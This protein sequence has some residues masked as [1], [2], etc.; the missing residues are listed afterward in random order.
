MNDAVAARAAALHAE[1]IV[2]DGHACLPSIGADELLPQIERYRQAGVSLLG[3]NIGDSDVDLAEQIR[4][5]A[6]IR[7]FVAAHPD[8]YRMAVRAADIDAAHKAGQLAILL[9][10]EGCFAMGDQLSLIE[11]YFDIGVRWMA[12]V[13]NR[14]NLVGGGVHDDADE[15]LTAFGRQVVAEMD[16]VG[17]VK[18]CSHTGYRTVLEVMAATDR[19][20]IF[21]HS[22][23]R[24]LRD[25]PRNIPDELIR[26]CASTG[27]VVGLSGV[28]IFLGDNDISVDAQV[29]HVDYVVQMVGPQH[30]GLG[31]DFVFDQAQMDEALERNGHLWPANFGYEPGIRF[32]PPE[33]LP[34][35]TEGLLRR[36]YAEADVRAVMGGNLMRV[37]REVWRT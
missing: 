10:I 11:F 25:H 15:G 2:W 34:A 32:V 36:G 5:A 12:M 29:R 22:N 7:A 4:M 13:Y 31:L 20:T 23:P 26:A 8:R 33:Q 3:L 6:R 18:C 28:G 37:A 16:R 1:A 30:V 14:R 17:M 9:N 19:P 35:L 24:V 27:G 21:S